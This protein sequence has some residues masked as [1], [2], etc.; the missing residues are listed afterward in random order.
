MPFAQDVGLKRQ[1]QLER[2]PVEGGVGQ[3]VRM[4]RAMDILGEQDFEAFGFGDIHHRSR[5]VSGGVEGLN[6]P[7]PQKYFF[8][9]AHELAVHRE[10]R[11][12]RPIPGGG[13]HPIVALLQEGRLQGMGH[14]LAVKLLPQGL[15]APGVVK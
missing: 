4:Q 2:A 1:Q 9:G 3:K 12:S 7:P 10:R 6:D 15:G 13:R 8:P 5:R 14:D 11:Q